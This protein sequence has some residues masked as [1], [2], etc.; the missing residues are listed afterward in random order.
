MSAFMRALGLRARGRWRRPEL[1]YAHSGS[2]PFCALLFF[3]ASAGLFVWPFTQG[4][5]YDEYGAAG[6]MALLALAVPLSGVCLA[7]GVITLAVSMI[8]REIRLAA[9]EVALR[10][11]E[12]EL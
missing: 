12:A 1:P 8:L 6:T 4:G 7:L 5:Y 10:E 2:G 3:L 9:Y 11:G